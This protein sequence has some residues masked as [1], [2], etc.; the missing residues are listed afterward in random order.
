MKR[1]QIWVPDW[2]SQAIYHFSIGIFPSTNVVGRY[3]ISPEDGN[4]MMSFLGSA[5]TFP[6]TKVATVNG[7]SKH[8]SE[9]FIHDCD[10]EDGIELLLALDSTYKPTGEPR[11]EVFWRTL[12]VNRVRGLDS[13]TWQEYFLRWWHLAFVASA[14]SA[15]QTQN[16]TV[17]EF[18][19]MIPNMA[20]L[21]DAEAKSG[22]ADHL[23]I[24]ES[25][26]QHVRNSSHGN[27]L[28]QAGYPFS[29]TFGEI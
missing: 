28:L 21:A 22:I 2:E 13:I 3:L 26:E 17:Q 6:A 14:M 16:I 12:I 20:K 9:F 24:V 1:S 25:F 5:L 4:L 18:L 19:K 11:L 8:L 27:D 29:L 7:T 23:T 15:N 10:F